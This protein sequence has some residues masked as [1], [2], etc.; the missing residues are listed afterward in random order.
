MQQ[1]RLAQQTNQRQ[2]MQQQPR[3]PITHPST[4][5]SLNNHSSLQKQNAEPTVLRSLIQQL[6][7]NHM[8]LL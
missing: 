7:L 6:P 1:L 3:R 8:N 5:Q 2:M 4:V